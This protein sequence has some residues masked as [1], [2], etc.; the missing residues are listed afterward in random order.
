M[1][2]AGKEYVYKTE[3]K[4]ARDTAAKRR[5]DPNDDEAAIAEWL[6]AQEGELNQRYERELMN[7]REALSLGSI[8]EI[9]MPADLRR[10]LGNNLEFLL[11]HYVPGPM[12][13]V[14]REFH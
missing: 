8:S 12:T 14:Q 2:P 5:K 1:G 4:H 11:R 13:G 10:V 3:L 9:V 6:K 7:P